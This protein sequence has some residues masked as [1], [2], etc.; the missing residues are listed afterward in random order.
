MRNLKK[1]LSL[2]M[3]FAMVLT[4]IGV[5]PS[6]V[7]YAAD[8]LGTLTIEVGTDNKVGVTGATAGSCLWYKI[9]NDTDAEY[10]TLA[11]IT[12]TVADFNST[13]FSKE[14]ITSVTEAD[15]GKYIYVIETASAD[16]AANVTKAGKS[17]KIV[18]TEKEEPVK[19]PVAV[20]EAPVIPDNAVRVP[21]MNAGK[22]VV[23]A[24]PEIA[25]A[26]TIEYVAVNHNNSLLGATWKSFSSDVRLEVGNW[27]FYVRA[28]NVVGTTTSGAYHIVVDDAA[29]VFEAPVVTKDA[30]NRKLMVALKANDALSGLEN[31][32]YSVDGS[33]EQVYTGPISI[34]NLGDHT[35]DYRAVDKAGNISAV[36]THKVTLSNA[37]LMVVPTVKMLDESPN[38][39]YIRFR[40]QNYNI[41]LFDYSYQ[42][43]EKGERVDR[44]AWEYCSGATYMDID[45]EGEWDL[46]VMVEYDDEY[47]DYAKVA[48]CVIDH[49]EPDIV[50]IIKPRSN[51]KGNFNITVDARDEYSRVLEYSFD[52]GKTWGTEESKTYRKATTILP[53]DIQVRDDAGNIAESGFCGIVELDGR[54]TVFTEDP[55]S[56]DSNINQKDDNTNNNDTNTNNGSNNG[57]NSGNNNNNSGSMY[58]TKAGVSINNQAVNNGYMSGYADNTFK[59]DKNI[60]RAELATILTRVFDFSTN[61]YSNYTDV[62]S[63][64]WASSNISAVQSYGMFQTNGSYFMPDASVTRAEV[65]HA[66]CQFIDT[67]NV[68]VGTN[69]Y[70]DINTSSYANDILK[71]SQL[72]IMNGYGNNMFGPNDVLTRAQV[73]AII[74]RLIG[75]KGNSSSIHFDDV[76][77]SHWAYSDIMLASR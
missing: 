53:G 33:A 26:D 68:S 58:N 7:A 49:T 9:S 77:T 5:M 43:V 36:Q 52:G 19:P 6:G 39:D 72:G 73:V 1:T 56:V 71:V 74:N 28:T 44:F 66:V 51:N 75:A 20:T 4:F 27:D 10:T 65:A 37:S 63:T 47:S 17:G 67:S 69:Q 42:F 76:S 11:D 70:L 62:S 22:S 25:N 55:D 29:P 57:N 35:I 59:P 14:A 54:K 32:Y 8:T 34:N 23:I 46:Y 64:H 15:N 13:G 48:S 16:D 2:F 38:N 21:E 60:T 12:K 45:E 40:L 31:I 30:E 61:N 50:K 41:E 24:V 18:Y 3:A